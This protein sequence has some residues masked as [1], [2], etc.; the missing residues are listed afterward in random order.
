MVSLGFVVV[1]QFVLVVPGSSKCLIPVRAQD[2]PGPLGKYLG[3]DVVNFLGSGLRFM[4]D[5][6]RNP[7]DFPSPIVLDGFLSH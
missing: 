3:F 5:S 2:S 1:V 4:L 7:L 6:V